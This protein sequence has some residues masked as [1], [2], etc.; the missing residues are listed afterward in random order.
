[1][2]MKLIGKLLTIAAGN[3]VALFVA[4]RFIG[5]FEVAPD[6]VNFGSVLVLLIAANLIIRPLAKLLFGP[7]IVITLGVFTI[8]INAGIL[9]AIDIYSPSLTINGLGTLFTAT[10][11]MSVINFII[12]ISFRPR[13][14]S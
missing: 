13:A 9:Y 8:I 5:G 1:M 11:V 10:V 2:N 12:Y 6:L 4:N 3:A 7:L 14:N